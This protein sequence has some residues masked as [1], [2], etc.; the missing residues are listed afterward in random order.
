[1]RTKEYIQ[2]CEICHK[3]YIASRTGSSVCSN[4]C[5]AKKSRDKKDKLFNQLLSQV[6]ASNEFEQ[7]VIKLARLRGKDKD[8]IVRRVRLHKQL[9]ISDAHHG[10]SELSAIDDLKEDIKYFTKRLSP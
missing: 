10:Y 7:L 8:W 4:K 6:P 3:T 5:R 1:M 9:L 2:T